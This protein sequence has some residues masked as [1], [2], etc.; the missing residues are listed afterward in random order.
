MI[1]KGCEQ[2][3]PVTNETNCDSGIKLGATNSK[4]SDQTAWMCRYICAFA[5]SFYLDVS[6]L[7]VTTY[8]FS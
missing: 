6:F 4:G 5:V 3:N 8:F 1:M 2:W 7:H